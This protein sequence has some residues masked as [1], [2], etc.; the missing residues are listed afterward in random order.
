MIGRGRILVVVAS[1]PKID[2]RDARGG[3]SAAPALIA[4]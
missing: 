4:K 1:R 3:G 2:S